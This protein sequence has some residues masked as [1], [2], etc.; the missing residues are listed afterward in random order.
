MKYLS[1]VG[2]FAL[3]GL[4]V[5]LGFGVPLTKATPNTT[6][7]KVVDTM[8]QIAQMIGIVEAIGQAAT[9]PMA[10]PE[11]LRVATPLVAQ[12]ILASSMLSGHKI[13]DELLFRQGC[14]KIASGM[15]D[16]MNSIK[17]QPPTIDKG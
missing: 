9:T 3:M 13:G 17:G 11:K 6:D 2:K 1:L 10:G 4:Q 15:A 8:V 16:V 7:D 5:L 12:V 14:E